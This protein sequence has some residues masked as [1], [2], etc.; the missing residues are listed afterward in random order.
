MTR[1]APYETISRSHLRADTVALGFIGIVLV[2]T[3]IAAVV[4]EVSPE[5]AHAQEAVV[6]IVSRRVSPA[7]AAGLPRGMQ[8][9]WIERLGRVDRCVTCHVGIDGG[10]ELAELP[11]PARSHPR[12]ELI[13]AHPVERFGCTLCHGGNGAATSRAA[14]HAE[15]P[16]A[17][18]PLLDATRARPYGL[19]ATELMEMRCN[20]CHRAEEATRWMPLLSSAKAIVKEKRCAS[21]HAIEG[22]GGTS[23]PD[24]SKTGEVPPERRH[25]PPAW[26]RPRTSLG[27][28][29]GHRS[30][31]TST[32]PGSEMTAFGFTEREATALSLLVS[33]W[34]RARLPAEWLPSRR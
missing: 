15:E 26:A 30:D 12:P 13:A 34:R 29:I 28:H 7:R 5:W 14:A 21:C 6:D 33:S 31:P 10:A 23:G 9:I 32:S 16:S 1:P 20:A 11:N 25:F 18:E 3:S 19:S 4:R 22:K 27:W 24:L 8:Q 2:A 17:D